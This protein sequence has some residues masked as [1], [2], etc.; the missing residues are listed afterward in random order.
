MYLNNFFLSDLK[1]ICRKQYLYTVGWLI[2]YKNV[3]SVIAQKMGEGTEIRGALFFTY[4]W[5]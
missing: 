2:R 4:N 5:N 1:V 3:I